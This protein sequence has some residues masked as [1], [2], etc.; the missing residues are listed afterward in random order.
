MLAYFFIVTLFAA[1]L[2]KERHCYGWCL[3]T[4][5][6]CFFEWSLMTFDAAWVA[7]AIVWAIAC[8]RWVYVFM[9]ISQDEDK[10]REEFL[11]S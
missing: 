10:A 8:S 1:F 4:S 6:L 3:I 5:I 2:R 11:L 7:S 9:T